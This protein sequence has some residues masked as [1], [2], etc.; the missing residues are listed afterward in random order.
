MSSVLDSN[1]LS[2]VS[3][4][5]GLCRWRALLCS[6]RMNASAG[7]ARAV[8]QPTTKSVTAKG[9]PFEPNTRRRRTGGRK[10]GERGGGSRIEG[11]EGGPHQSR[12]NREGAAARQRLDRRRRGD[13]YSTSVKQDRGP[14]SSS[15]PPCLSP[16][17][18]PSQSLPPPPFP[19][20]VHIND[21]ASDQSQDAACKQ[22]EL[23]L[24]RKAAA[25]LLI[26]A[27][28]SNRRAPT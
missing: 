11:G 23:G 20:S 18:P 22:K 16:P 10:E 19:R 5:T 28:V 25:S 3:L 27:Q 14:N 17:H 21:C 12:T 4:A 13:R 26:A 24:V 8:L 7:R 2:L 15:V 9:L 1:T 6:A